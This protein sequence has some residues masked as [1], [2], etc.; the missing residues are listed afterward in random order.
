MCGRCWSCSVPLAATSLLPAYNQGRHTQKVTAAPVSSSRH[1]IRFASPLLCQ[2][3]LTSD[4]RGFWLPCIS[5]VFLGLGP[6]GPLAVIWVL[7]LFPP[8]LL[9]SAL[10]PQQLHAHL[11]CHSPYEG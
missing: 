9:P 11:D 1:F 7:K 8:G 5:C 4:F 3:S 10:A 2:T 6:G